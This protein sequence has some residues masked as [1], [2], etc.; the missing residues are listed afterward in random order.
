VTAEVSLGPLAPVGSSAKFVTAYGIVQP[1]DFAFYWQQQLGIFH[2]F[3]IVSNR[4]VL[5][6]LGADS[7]EKWSS[8]PWLTSVGITMPRLVRS[9]LER[10]GQPQRADPLLA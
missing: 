3:Y 10:L 9:V 5:G 6:R 8:K 4:V 7:T 2:V 1:K